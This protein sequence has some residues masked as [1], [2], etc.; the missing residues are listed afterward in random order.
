MAKRSLFSRL[1]K[2]ITTSNCQGRLDKDGKHWDRK[3]TQGY[4]GHTKKNSKK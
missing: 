1:I 2:S 4:H 3:G